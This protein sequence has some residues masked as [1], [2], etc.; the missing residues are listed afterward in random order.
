[1]T[2]A[3]QSTRSH[4]LSLS[5]LL[6]DVEEKIHREKIKSEGLQAILAD[7]TKAHELVGTYFEK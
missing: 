3:K 6:L 1:M 7:L 2:Q 5:Q 4:R